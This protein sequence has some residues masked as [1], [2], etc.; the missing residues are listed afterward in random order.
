[1]SCLGGHLGLA[2]RHDTHS[3]ELGTTRDMTWHTVRPA[4]EARHR[5]SGGGDR[6]TR[7]DPRQQRVVPRSTPYPTGWHDTSRLISRAS[8]TVSNQIHTVQDRAAR[9]DSSLFSQNRDTRDTP[10]Q[11]KKSII[12]MDPSLRPSP[13]CSSLQAS[14]S[15]DPLVAASPCGSLNRTPFCLPTNCAMQHTAFFSDISDI[16]VNI[17]LKFAILP[18]SR[19]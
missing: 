1:M 11:G 17:I 18:C 7:H 10:Y 9:L 13:A 4:T 8:C 14:C 6:R 2:A 12:S 16:Y 3:I 5:D 19:L 15:S